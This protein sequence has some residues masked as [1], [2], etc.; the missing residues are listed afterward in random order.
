MNFRWLALGLL[1]LTVGCWNWKPVAATSEDFEPSLNVLA[2]LCPDNGGMVTVAVQKILPLEG[3]ETVAGPP[4]SICQEY[5]WED[6]L[7]VDCYPIIPQLSLYRVLDATVTLFDGE[8]TWVLVYDDTWQDDNFREQVKTAYYTPVD[9]TFVPLEEATYDLHVT[10]PEGLEATGRV[11][12]PRAP[13]FDLAHWDDS[14]R[15]GYIYDLRW[16]PTTGNYRIGLEMETSFPD[17]MED[18]WPYTRWL[19]NLSYQVGVQDSTTWPLLIEPRCDEYGPE[20]ASFP[21]DTLTISLMA[22]DDNF[23]EYFFG[24]QT[25]DMTLF[26]LGSGDTGRV[27][28]IEGGLGVIGAYRRISL[29]IWVKPN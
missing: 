29:E 25:N 11:T 10:T 15:V 6:S 22:M 3:P 13:E 23:Y 19:C 9:T 28:G 12:I 1:I 17:T 8:K 20:P 18:G 7:I 24:E 14:L 27:N 26:L 4:D 5:F 21:G 2:I 16:T